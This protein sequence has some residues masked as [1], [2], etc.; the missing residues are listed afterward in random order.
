MGTTSKAIAKLFNEC[1]VQRVLVSYA[2]TD[3][4]AEF[5]LPFSDVMLDSGAYGVE[6]GTQIVT[7]E[8]YGLWLELYLT[9]YPQIKHYVNLDDLS[10]PHKSIE[11]LAYFES[12]GLSP[13]PVYHYGEPTE[14]LTNMC[15]KHEYVGL[16]GMAVGTM[17]PKN[18]KIFWEWAHETYPDVKFHLFGATSMQTIVKYQPYSMDSSSWTVGGRFGQLLGYK[19]GIPTRAIA[20]RAKEGYKIFLDSDDFAKANIR[21]ILDW[22]KLEWLKNMNG[23]VKTGQQQMLFNE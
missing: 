4:K 12:C 1:N 5:N 8:A 11:N 7:K 15:K 2:D 21:A 9:K 22:E 3:G 10:N 13:I 20:P 17:P 14:F 18:L 16:G 19:D 6:T 23:N